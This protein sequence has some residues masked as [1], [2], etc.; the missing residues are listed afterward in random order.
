MARLQSFPGGRA[1]KIQYGTFATFTFTIKFP[2]PQANSSVQGFISTGTLGAAPTIGTLTIA[3]TTVTLGAGDII[4]PQA[5]AKKIVATSISGFTT[6][7]N[8]NDPLK[9]TLINT[10]V[11]SQTKPTLALGT[12][13]NILFTDSVYTD[14]SNITIGAQDDIE[15]EGRTPQTIVVTFSGGSIPTV[16]ASTG[17]EQEQ[18]AGT[19]TYGAALTLGTV[20]GIANAV[21]ISSPIHYIKL[22][23]QTGNTTASVYI[24]R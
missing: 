3:G 23:T 20:N 9:V 12:A 5:V 2:T 4:N 19:L 13:T 6:A 1:A 7:W 21:T 14:G 17:T 18:A 15:V 10:T 16:I 11:G 22:T 24:M 8:Q